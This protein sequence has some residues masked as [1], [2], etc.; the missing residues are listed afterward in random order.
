MVRRVPLDEN[1]TIVLI[2]SALYAFQRR[3]SY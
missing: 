2:Q 1:G 3:G